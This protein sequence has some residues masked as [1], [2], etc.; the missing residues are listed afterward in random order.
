MGD[1]HKHTDLGRISKVVAMVKDIEKALAD[2][3]E[4][5]TTF[6]KRESLFGGNATEYDSLQKINAEFEVS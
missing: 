6:N 3:G 4:R 1:F 2:Y 5:A